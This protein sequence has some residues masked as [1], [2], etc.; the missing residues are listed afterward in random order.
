MSRR[1][2]SVRPYPRSRRGA[3]RRCLH[4]LSPPHLRPPAPRRPPRPVLPSPRTSASSPP[5]P[6]RVVLAWKRTA[7]RFAVSKNFRRQAVVRTRVYTYRDLSCGRSFR[8][9]VRAISRAG[10]VSRTAT[11][12][13]RT[14]PCPPVPDDG[15]PASVDAPGLSG[16]AAVGGVLT[17]SDGTWAGAV[18]MAYAYEWLRCDSTGWA[19]A[20]ILGATS[21]TYLV[22]AADV[23]SRLRA[24]VTATNA[25]GYADATSA[26]TAVVGA[27]PPPPPDPP[28]PPPPPPRLRRRPP[29][30]A[31]A[32]TS[33]TRRRLRARARRS[34]ST[35]GR[36][37]TPVAAS[38][39]ATGTSSVPPSSGRSRRP[40]SAR[41]RACATAST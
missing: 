40:S 21:S 4:R 28:P 32:P 12:R 37:R 1:T 25:L 9:G 15:P 27:T 38:P 34:S 5:P 16:S 26:A 7:R 6:T 8:L 20:P 23:G 22:S 24:R 19:C 36:A 13:A 41:A 3:R 2:L 33:G 35:S 11:I 29:A 18:P 14:L 30:C 10:R 39:T 31:P 17:T